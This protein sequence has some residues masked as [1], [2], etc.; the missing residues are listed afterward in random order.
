MK[1]TVRQDGTFIFKWKNLVGGK[2]RH[3]VLTTNDGQHIADAQN[4]IEVIANNPDTWL[5]I[6]STTYTIANF[7]GINITRLLIKHQ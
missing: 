7:R 6:N 3:M 1:A 5:D 4:R 2:I